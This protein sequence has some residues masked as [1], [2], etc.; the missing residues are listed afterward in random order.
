[1][2]N[3]TYEDAVLGEAALGIREAIE[4]KYS[5]NYPSIFS[6]FKSAFESEANF[7]NSTG[8]VYKDYVLPH[9]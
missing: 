6:A 8:E 5:K 2:D 3:A 7:N 4:N 1:M 9:A